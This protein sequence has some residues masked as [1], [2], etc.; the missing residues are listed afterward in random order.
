MGT[1]LK[2]VNAVIDG[3]PIQRCFHCRKCTAGC[4]LAFAMEYNPDK[5][6]RMIQMDRRSEVLKSDTIWL[7]VSCETCVTR[8]PNEVDIA[9]MMDVLREMAIEGGFKAKEKNILKLHESFLSCIKSRG[10]INEPLLVADY[11][12]KSGDLSSDLAMGMDMYLKGK[13]AL[14]SPRTRDMQAVRSIF[15]KTKKT[16]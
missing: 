10:R 15:E 5:I 14:L 1:F 7:C 12:L 2:E 3:V 16:R 9:R 11:N 4:P 8:C 6:V 13:L